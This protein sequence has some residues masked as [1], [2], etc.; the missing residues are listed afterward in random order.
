MKK[1]N[2]H[3][4]GKKGPKKPFFKKILPV[5]GGILGAPAGTAGIALGVN[6]GR[7]LAAGKGFGSLTDAVRKQDV[8]GIVGDKVDKV[9]G[10]IS[11][12]DGQR[13]QALNALKNEAS[14]ASEDSINKS[15]L[16]KR[17]MKTRGKR[18]R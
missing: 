12:K 7:G 10:L 13:E 6:V 9:E 8:F 15:I 2:H 1:K 5:L 14:K 18:K 11:G 17:S 3:F 4:K 16:G